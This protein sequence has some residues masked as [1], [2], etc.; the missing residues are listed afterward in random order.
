[1]DTIQLQYDNGRIL[2]FIHERVLL[3]RELLSDA[4][5][6]YLHIDCKMGHY[7]KNAGMYG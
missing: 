1:M 5:S 3:M 6:I 7:I 4:G 2:E